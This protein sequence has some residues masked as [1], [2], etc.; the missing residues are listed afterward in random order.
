[1]GFLGS[2]FGG[3]K[4][5]VE[6]SISVLNRP[7]ETFFVFTVNFFACAPRAAPL[8]TGMPDEA[9]LAK[10][11]EVKPAPLQGG[12]LTDVGE[13]FATRLAPGHYQVCVLALPM[14]LEP[15]TETGRPRVV[16]DPNNRFAFWPQPSA[17]E[18]RDQKRVLSLKLDFPRGLGKF[19]ERTGSLPLL[20]RIGPVNRAAYTRAAA[21][22]SGGDLSRSYL[23][24]SDAL[25]SP[26]LGRLVPADANEL[27]LVLTLGQ[28]K[29]LAQGGM[30]QEA[31]ACRQHLFGTLLPRV[32]L[33]EA[34]PA[35]AWDVMSTIAIA[36]ARDG[37]ADVVIDSLPAAIR[38]LEPR[39]AAR[40]E[41][42]EGLVHGAMALLRRG[43]ELGRRR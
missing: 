28:F 20:E 40:H 7:S 36:A 10:A 33:T 31:E 6:G 25:A 16:T 15:A 11:F 8:C 32:R 29:C 30:V 34:D 19:G 2:V 14:V 42:V 24:Y 21:L 3:G 41:G 23:A 38:A 22:A 39:L 27:R 12:R 37:R 13:Q 18:V 43:A 9:L 17:F 35:T 4:V 5:D 26:E 1:M